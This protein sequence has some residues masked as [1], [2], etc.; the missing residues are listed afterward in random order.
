VLSGSRWSIVF[1]AVAVPARVLG[2]ADALAKLENGDWQLC[3]FLT[4]GPLT[5]KPES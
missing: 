1:M 5:S 2:G 4:G 3:C